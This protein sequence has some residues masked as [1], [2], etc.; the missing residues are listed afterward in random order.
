MNHP[1]GIRIDSRWRV[2][3]FVA[4]VTGAIALT[5]WLATAALL[6]LGQFDVVRPVLIITGLVP[7]LII[8]PVLYWLARALHQ[9]TIA[10]VELQRLAHT[11]DLTGLSNRRAFF[12]QGDALIHAAVQEQQPLGLLFFD[13]DNFKHVNDTL[14]HLAGDKALRYLAQSIAS[15]V[16]EGDL[17]ARFGG[18]EFA[19]LRCG[20]TRLEMAE[21]AALIQNQLDTQPFV[22]RNIPF[23]LSM[24]AG[25]ADTEQVRTFDDLL[26]ATDVALYHRKPGNHGSHAGH[27]CVEQAN[28]EHP[29]GE[30]LAEAGDKGHESHPPT[31]DRPQLD[32]SISR[33]AT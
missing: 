24:S 20:A 5:S 33:N 22:Y 25:V 30:L 28:E 17:V 3:S 14:G 15:C 6:W 18:D 12:Q 23:P 11:D 31:L 32:L 27:I 10:Q 21:L 26:S 1:L 7:L 2:W 9:L 4:L 29:A 13:A 19:V 16:A 8:F